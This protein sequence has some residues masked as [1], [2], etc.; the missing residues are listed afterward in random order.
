MKKPTPKRQNQKVWTGE[1]RVSRPALVDPDERFDKPTYQIVALFDP[2]DPTLELLKEAAK[3]AWESKFAKKKFSEKKVPIFDGSDE[4]HCEK[5]GYD[6]KLF[7]YA[8]SHADKARPKCYSLT[9]V[10][11]EDYEIEE[12]IYPGCYCRATIFVNAY[13]NEQQG[14]QFLL[15][16]VQHLRDG[17]PLKETAIG[18]T[19]DDFNDDFSKQTE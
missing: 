17:E 5:D 13:D 3:E 16:A 15:N 9:N 10:P 4:D 2:D 8:K 18:D 7:L 19:D 12:N 14:I 11:L 6:G 1:F